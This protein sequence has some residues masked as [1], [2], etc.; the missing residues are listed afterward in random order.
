MEKE[1]KDL[2]DLIINNL[3]RTTKTMAVDYMLE[4]PEKMDL[5]WDWLNNAQDPLKWRSAWVFEEACILNSELLI[6]YKDRI[7]QLFPTLDH[8]PLRRMLGNILSK[9]EIPEDYESEILDASLTWLQDPE[10]PAAVRVHCMTIV[11]NLSKKYPELQQELK[12]ILH[13]WY[14]TGS[15]GFRNRAGKILKKIT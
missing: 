5:L 3:S 10:M 7:A 1:E 6:K 13:Y 9:T 14:E 15:A 8:V 2:Q 4:C 12:E 11:F